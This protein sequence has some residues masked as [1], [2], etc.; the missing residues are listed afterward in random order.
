MINIRP[1]Q[2][3]DWPRLCAIHDAARLDE[4]RLSVGIEAFL[5]LAQA[6]ETEGLFDN[7][8]EVAEVAGQVLGFV[9]YTDTDLNWLYVDPAVYGRG[10]GRALVRHAIASAGPVLGLE[11]LEG[12]EPALKLYLAEGFQILKRAEGRLTGN[13]SFPAAGYVL[14]RRTEQRSDC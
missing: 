12:N 14:E 3:A 9:A 11:V 8:V 6:A 7:R 1:Y 4:L 2:P 5:P 10:I 13:E